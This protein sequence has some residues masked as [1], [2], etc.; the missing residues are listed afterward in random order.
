MILLIQRPKKLLEG[1]IDQFNEFSSQADQRLA[2][3]SQFSRVP[4]E[5][6][7]IY[8]PIYETTPTHEIYL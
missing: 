5:G 7:S 2:V 1:N 3:E 8:L 6:V 4:V